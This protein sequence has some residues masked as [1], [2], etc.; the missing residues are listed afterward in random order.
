M[1]VRAGFHGTVGQPSAQVID[2]SLLFDGS[3][4]Y[5]KRTPLSSGNR[6]TFTISFW[7]KYSKN[8]TSDQFWAGTGIND[9]WRARARSDGDVRLQVYNSGSN[10]ANEKTAAFFRD[11]GWYHFVYAVDTT[12]STANDRQ[13][14]YV[15]GVLQDVAS[16]GSNPSE[17]L[18]VDVNHTNEHRIGAGDDGSGNSLNYYW[19][20]RMSQVYLIDGQALEPEN[21]GFTDPLT[22]TWKPKKFNV[23][24]ADDTILVGSP[25]YASSDF[26]TEGNKTSDQTGLSFGAWTSYT[27]A[28]TKIFKNSTDTVFTLNLYLTNG[29]TDR[30]LWYSNNLTDWTFVGNTNPNRYYQ[31]SGFKYYAT[32]E[33]SGSTTLEAISKNGPNSFYLPMDG[34]SPIGEDKSGNGNDWTAVNFGGSVALIIQKYLVQGLF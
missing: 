29:T 13:K 1:V 15:N 25:T 28:E 33:G 31:L 2:G 27:G 19:A 14:I 9:N 16:G 12:Q 17:N 23:P 11:T 26:K 7:A 21:F 4:T 5:L 20:G 32:S 22:N 30:L 24:K 10:D 18:K 8:Q 3:S 6:R 34:N